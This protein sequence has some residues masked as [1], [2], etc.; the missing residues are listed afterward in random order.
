MNVNVI[1][2]H[3]DIDSRQLLAAARECVNKYTERVRDKR[4][5]NAGEYLKGYKPASRMI[6][7][8]VIDDLT[9]NIERSFPLMPPIMYRNNIGLRYINKRLCCGLGNECT[10]PADDNEATCAIHSLDDS[11]WTHETMKIKYSNGIISRMCSADNCEAVAYCDGFCCY[12][13]TILLQSIDDVNINELDIITDECSL[14]NNIRSD[15]ETASLESFI[16]ELTS[17]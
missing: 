4:L 8:N 9:K 1:A 17:D 5:S 11:V 2:I 14:D 7:S 16:N 13:Y 3:A 6:I 15:D 12:H 10:A